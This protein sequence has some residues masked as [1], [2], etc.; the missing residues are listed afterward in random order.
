M[1]NFHVL[2]SILSLT[3]LH[4]LYLGYNYLCDLPDEVAQEN[5]EDFKVGN[6]S[7]RIQQMIMDYQPLVL[8]AKKLHWDPTEKT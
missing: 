5:N 1:N 2:G 8:V 7:R 6:S 4:T 3:I